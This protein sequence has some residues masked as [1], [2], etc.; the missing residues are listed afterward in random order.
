MM[1]T[2][3][4]IELNES[5]Y[6]GLIVEHPTGIQYMNQVAG[7]AC[8]HPVLEGFYFPLFSGEFGIEQRVIAVF[9][10]YGYWD[11]ITD[12]MADQID[13]LLSGFYLT[14]ELRVD[15]SRLK[16]SYE[17]WVW[18]TG[19]CQALTDFGEIRAVI[20]WENSD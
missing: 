15:R 3:P 4:V 18:V 2:K 7:Y 11:G 1:T 16:E 12:Q 5:A 20:T 10:E 14:R 19:R 9:G 8:Y 17:A 6:F 13:S